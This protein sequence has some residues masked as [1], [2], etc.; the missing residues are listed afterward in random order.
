MLQVYS[1]FDTNEKSGFSTVSIN[2]EVFNMITGFNPQVP[3]VTQTIESNGVKSG[4]RKFTVD[5]VDIWSKYDKENKVNKFAMKTSDAKELLVAPR[6]ESA[7]VFIGL[8][9]FD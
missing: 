6:S 9:L 2:R 1:I 8:P 4:V 3:Y 5:N 7:E